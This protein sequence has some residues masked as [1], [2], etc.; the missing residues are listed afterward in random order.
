MKQG[1]IDR[2]NPQLQNLTVRKGVFREVARDILWKDRNARK[3]G[4]S[5]DTGGS[6]ARALE[7]AYKL[8]LA[9]ATLGEVPDKSK[10]GEEND[11][12]MWMSLP[13]RPR[14]AFDSMIRFDWMVVKAPNSKLFAAQPD[15]WACY[16]DRGESWPSEDRLVFHCSYAISTLRPIVSLGLMEEKVVKGVTCLLITELGRGTW[17]LGILAGHIRPRTIF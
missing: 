12:V 11:L 6:I 3:S 2:D 5:Q 13:S 10:P 16:F 7:Q 4:A 14:Q 9:H 8:G 15:V 17:E 1:Y